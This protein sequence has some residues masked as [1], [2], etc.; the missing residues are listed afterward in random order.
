MFLCVFIYYSRS[1][2]KKD[3]LF[4]KRRY[5]LAYKQQR[6][7]LG[8]Q[9]GTKWTA[10]IGSNECLSVIQCRSLLIQIILLSLDITLWY[11]HSPHCPFIKI[12]SNQLITN[13]TTLG[14]WQAFSPHIVSTNEEIQVEEPENL[15]SSAINNPEYYSSFGPTSSEY[16]KC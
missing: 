16:G 3:Y 10:N 4:D 15:L 8:E 9:C 2:M 5:S 14:N 11:L 6:R 12:R 13:T 7:I 1:F